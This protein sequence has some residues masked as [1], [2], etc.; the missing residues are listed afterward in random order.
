[1]S[2]SEEVIFARVRISQ[3]EFCAQPCTISYILIN[4]GI[5]RLINIT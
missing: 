5:K 4:N 2:A 1:M 3:S